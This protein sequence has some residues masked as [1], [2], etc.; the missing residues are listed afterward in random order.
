MLKEKGSGNKVEAGDM[1]LHNL[2]N[3]ERDK[4]AVERQSESGRSG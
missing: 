2:G 4:V 3:L 1:G